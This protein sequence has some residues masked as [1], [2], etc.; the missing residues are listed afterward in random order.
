MD[1]IAEI[2]NLKAIINKLDYHY[3]TLNKPLESDYEYDRLIRKLEQL[4]IEAKYFTADSP[5]QRVSG[6]PTKEF[7]SINHNYPMLS[8]SNTYSTEELMD[9]DKRIKDLLDED[10]VYEYFCELKIDGLAVSLVYQNDYF[11]TGATRGDGISGDDISPNL[12]TIRSIPLKILNKN[13]W[14]M[15]NHYLPIPE[16]RQLAH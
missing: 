5:T 4:E 12:K 11:Q 9:F 16:M 3:Y 10:E 6:T 14:K 13:K 15:R 8:L 7:P 2:E 1:K